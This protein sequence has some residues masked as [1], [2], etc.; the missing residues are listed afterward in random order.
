METPPNEFEQQLL[1][2]LARL[3]D[4]KWDL[5]AQLHLNELARTAILEVLRGQ[6]PPA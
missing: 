1:A 3:D 4:E 5:M 2:D 6:R